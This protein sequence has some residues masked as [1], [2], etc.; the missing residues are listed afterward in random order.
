[1]TAT[2]HELQSSLFDDP[3]FEEKSLRFAT[4][5]G[6]Q[7]VYITRERYLDVDDTG[8]WSDGRDIVPR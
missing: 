3:S 6:C 4:D 1:M 2:S 7:V 8:A 5:A